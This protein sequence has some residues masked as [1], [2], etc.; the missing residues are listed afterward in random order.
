LKQYGETA[1]MLAA[2]YDNLEIVRSLI[3]SG[4][5]IDTCDEVSESFIW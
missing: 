4:S 1:L 3:A 5:D 2:K